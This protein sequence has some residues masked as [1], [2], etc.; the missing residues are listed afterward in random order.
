MSLCPDTH[1]L[2]FINTS[3]VS[4][5]AFFVSVRGHACSGAE[6]RQLS[7]SLSAVPNQ[8]AAVAV[9]TFILS[10][11]PNTMVDVCKIVG[12]RSHRCA[13][14][15]SDI[16]TLEPAAPAAEPSAV[17]PL[18]LRFPLPAGLAYLCSQSEHGGLSH[19]AHASTRFAC[20]FDAPVGT[21]VLAAGAGRVLALEQEAPAGGNDCALFFRYNSLTLQ[22]TGPGL[23]HVVEYVHFLA[24]SATV[25]VG[26][27]V[28]EGQQI[29]LTGQAGFCPTPHLH[30]EAH[31]GVG[32]DPVAPSVPIAFY[33]GEGPNAELFVP[34]AGAW[35][36]SA[37]TARAEPEP[38]AAAAAVKAVSD[39][40]GSGSESSSGGWE[41]V[42]DEDYRYETCA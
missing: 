35:Y 5:K 41:T 27:T 30:I 23:A 13:D 8:A 28:A 14:I 3:S 26:D 34:V 38:P 1:V 18:Q 12:L 31:L 33:T 7:S 36:P 29:C 22:L 21:P 2:T 11:P 37:C 25:R 24:G 17:P 20:D 40:A 32:D 39:A 19:F 9:T 16:V 4:S 15:Y 42:S 6:G 10:L